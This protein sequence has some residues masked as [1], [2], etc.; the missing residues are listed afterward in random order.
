MVETYKILTQKYD[1]KVCTGLLELSNSST[2]GHSLKISKQHAN[3]NIKKFFFTHRVV[4]AWNR[5]TETVVSAPSIQ[6]FE[7]RLD[8]YW[9]NHPLKFLYN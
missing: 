4:D 7:N 2:R 5:L 9:V 1:T 8:K 3:C 6:A